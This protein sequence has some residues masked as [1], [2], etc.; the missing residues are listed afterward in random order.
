MVL[1]TLPSMAG[2]QRLYDS[3]GFRDIEPYR[4][5]PVDGTRFMALDL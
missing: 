1:D 5:N 2:A 3:L 4:Y